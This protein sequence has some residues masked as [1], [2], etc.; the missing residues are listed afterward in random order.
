MTGFILLP[1]RNGGGLYLKPERVTA[2]LSNLEQDGTWS[3]SIVLDEGSQNIL[4]AGLEQAEANGYARH[5]V[6]LLDGTKF[7]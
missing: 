2:I 5:L 1:L 4:D 3:V 7:N 6:Q